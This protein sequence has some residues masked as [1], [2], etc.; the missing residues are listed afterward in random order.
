[1]E[2][3]ILDKLQNP[4][5]PLPSL[6]KSLGGLPGAIM[7]HSFS[8]AHFR[9]VLEPEDRLTLHPRNPGN[10][11]RGAFG[12]T[13]KRLVC[14]TSHECRETCRQKA[15]CPYGQIFEPS[16]P[17]DSDRLS[18]NQDI[19]RPFVFRPPNGNETTARPGEALHF[20]LILIGKALEYFP[21]FLVTF[22]ELGDQG[23]GLGRGRYRIARVSMLNEDG[24]DV[25][26]VYSGHDNIVRPSP[27]RIT[28]KDCCRLAAL[29]LTN[30]GVRITIRFLTPT[31]LKVDGKLVERPE[32]HHIIKR[33]RDRVNALA[34][35]YCDDRLEMD[36]KSFGER[37]EVVRTVS[38]KVRWEDRDRRSWKTGLS[39]D[40]GGFVGEVTYE[41]NLQEFLPLLILGQYTHVGKYA[42]WGNGRYEVVV[43]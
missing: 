37:A 33:L 26:D 23:I 7:L 12:S 8:F 20:D 30:N 10:T 32:F 16:P 34:H 31:L 11:L 17:T 43:L 6:S 29:R 2:P 40:M 25:G 41:G 9:F 38:C 14:P 24:S 22:R 5:Y 19:P 4:H 21:Y 3:G 28:Y 36:Y 39:H 1:M 15:T 42:V 27:F 18:L 35:F 13:F